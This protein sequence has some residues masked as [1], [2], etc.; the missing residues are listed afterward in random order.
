MPTMVVIVSTWRRRRGF[1]DAILRRSTGE[2]LYSGFPVL[3]SGLD[4]LDRRSHDR[5]QAGSCSRFAIMA[6]K[7]GRAWQVSSQALTRG[8]AENSSGAAIA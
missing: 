2:G 6:L 3:Q 1:K 8:A 5:S 7:A 4:V